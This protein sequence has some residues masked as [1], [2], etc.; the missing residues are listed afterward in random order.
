MEETSTHVPR[1]R[2]VGEDRY[3][4]EIVRVHGLW[5]EAKDSLRRAQAELAELQAAEGSYGVDVADR[6]RFNELQLDRERGRSRQLQTSLDD[7]RMA[8]ALCE[9]EI[10]KQAAERRVEA[11]QLLALRT[12]IK[13][14]HD[15]KQAALEQTCRELRLRE[16]EVEEL[17]RTRRRLEDKVHQQELDL[18]RFNQVADLAGPLRLV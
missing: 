16:G 11:E 18:S 2:E 13:A 15:E 14:L 1:A 6:L 7:S 12:Q 5:R 10:D 8:L 9:A 17:E 4:H 3:K